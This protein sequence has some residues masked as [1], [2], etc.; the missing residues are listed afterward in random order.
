MLSKTAFH[1]WFRGL[2]DIQFKL[3]LGIVEVRLG[4][5]GAN[6]RS[7]LPVPVPL[8]GVPVLLFKC[9]RFLCQATILWEV[10]P[11]SAQLPTPLLHLEVSSN[12]PSQQEQNSFV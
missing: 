7:A 6:A 12:A 1:I 2:G 11:P 10:D 5:A 3:G 4:F 9:Q 8:S